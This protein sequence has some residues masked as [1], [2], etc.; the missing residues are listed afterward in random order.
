MPQTV[1]PF[2][3]EKTLEKLTAHAG[4]VLAGEYMQALNLNRI[5]DTHMPSAKSA[6]G[7]RASNYIQ[8]LILMLLGG[9]QSIADMRVIKNDI[10]LQKLLNIKMIPSESAIGD[11]LS[12]LG[13]KGGLDGLEKVQSN[14]ISIALNNESQTDYTLDIDATQIISHKDSAAYTYKG[15]K[16]YMPIVGHIAENG[17]VIGDDFRSGNIAPASE[18]FEFIKY[19]ESQLPTGKRFSAIRIDSAG[20]QADIINYC[21]QNNQ[22]FAIGAPLD[23]AIKQGVLS[24]PEDQWEKYKDREIAEMVHCMN[25]TNKAFR[26]IVTRKARQQDLFNH[27]EDAYFYHAIASNKTETASDV[28]DWYCQRGETSE[29]KIKELKLGMGMDRM[30][31]GSQEGNA[32]FFRIGVLAYNISIMFKTDVLPEKWQRYQIKTVR[33]QLFQVAGKVVTGSRYL[34]LKINETYLVLFEEIRTLIWQRK[35]QLE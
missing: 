32:L 25:K 5:I 28:K 20:Y 11:W 14:L 34:K 15:E 12:R 18:N 3:L 19:C 21:E 17:L 2:K 7:Y 23:K 30:P 27:D 4:L 16:G 35:C 31:C 6:V 33:W 29:N 10:S 26:L 13:K 8:A 9:G 1:L 24:I 22:T